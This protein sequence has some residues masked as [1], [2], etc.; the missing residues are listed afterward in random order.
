MSLT[1][2]FIRRPVMTC[3]LMIGILVF[4]IVSYRKLPVS[5]LPTVEYPTISVDANLPG[6]SPET[7]AATVATPLEKAFSAVGGIDEITSSSRLGSTNITLQFSLDRDVEA[8][9]QDVNAAIGKTLPYLP[10]T[11][12]P[13][14]YHKQNPSAMPIMNIALTS[15]ELPM[16]R[17]DEYGQTFIAQRLS[18]I[19][20]VASVGVFG[21]AKYAVRVQLDPAQ[22]AVRNIGVSQVA[23]AIRNNNV[24][25]PTGV[26]Y[27]KDKTLTVMATGQMNNATEFRRLIITYRNG[28]AVRLGDVANVLDDIQNN[29][30]VSWYQTER[31]VNLMVQRQPGT[32]TVDVARRVKEALVEI[33]KGLP[34]TLKVHIQYDRS[35]SIQNAVHDVKVSLLV[36]LVLVVAVIFI[37]LRSAVATLIPSL[38][39]PLAII[40]T[41]SVMFVLKFSIDNLSLMAL[42]LAV[43]FVVDD[44]IVML[45][46]I[47]RHIEMGKSPMTAALDGAEEVGYT[48]LSMCLSLSAVFIPLMFMGGIIGRLFREFAITISVAVLVSGMVALTLTPMMCSRL[49]KSH[50]EQRKTH[51]R[52]FNF[53]ERTFDGALHG[54]ERSLAWVMRHRPLALAF[55]AIIL[56]STAGLWSVIPKGLFPP[57]D[58]G[59]LNAT[60]EAPQGTTFVEML[61]FGKLVAAKLATDTNVASYTVNVGGMGSS[62]QIQYNITL[63]PAGH[64]PPADE[65]VHELSRVMSGVPSVQIFVTNPPAIR[66]GGRGTKTSY[67]YTLHG[68]DIAQLYDQGS[69]LMTRLQD[70]PL[71]SGVTSDLLNRSPIIR[72]HIDRQRAASLGVTPSGIEQALANA[73][74]QQQVST[75]FMPTNQYYVVMETVPSAQ[76][77][78][79]SLEHFFVPSPGGR[80]IPLTDVS[81]FEMTTGPLSV[82]HSGQMASMT[83]SFNLAPNVSLGAATVEVERISRQML[84]QTITGGWAGTAQA[85]EDSQKGLGL[86]LLITIFIIYIILGI[87][88]ESFIHPITILTG[89]PFAAFGALF[90]L[91][92]THVELGVYGYVGIIMLI[93]IVEKNAIMMIDFAL[94]RQRSE[95]IPPAT[96][97]I[98]AASVR[99]RP[100]MMTTVSAI[101]GTL[102]IAIG[103][104]TSAASRRPLGI[105][106]VGGLAFSQ[107]VT[108]YVTPVFY[109]YF[110]ELQ[111]WLGRRAHEAAPSSVPGAVPVAG[112]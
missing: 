28:A 37:F 71:L 85:F 97:I 79:N 32:N 23:A 92:V 33:E 84:P 38:T 10:S 103:V 27:G 22:L 89:L 88:Y 81:T 45:E 49:L 1:A 5:D 8:A 12:L 102:P 46:N 58:T 3:L 21:S 60:A 39:L 40:G 77:D 73:F 30:S 94:A 91:Y 4:G 53:A 55:S 47:V 76:L 86:L 78:A 14:N 6:A 57:D 13:P 105:A 18:M 99:F 93:G 98:E 101:V 96:A 104:G 34:P 51:G 67:Q 68:S 25:L 20:G 42:T 66:I 82:A 62:N 70:S 111:T 16:T 35:I 24:M 64:R 107:I 9:A 15:N 7:M 29:K 90:A 69:R 106:V 36:A 72:V 44:A 112:D 63:K 110:D 43:G 74:N 109:T 50:A 54:Y 11:I 2:L 100:I 48:V 95:H 31:S 52:L 80:Q 61:R 26:L 108:L 56:A 41:F 75:I 87:L 59:S 65:M 17:V 83:I 19:E